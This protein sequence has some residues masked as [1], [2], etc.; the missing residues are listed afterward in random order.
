M[1]WEDLFYPERIKDDKEIVRWVSTWTLL[2]V[3]A[4]I[5]VLGGAI[6]C[7]Q[8]TGPPSHRPEEVQTSP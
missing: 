2:I 4:V 1:H 7:A 6:V 5:V 3:S 8:I